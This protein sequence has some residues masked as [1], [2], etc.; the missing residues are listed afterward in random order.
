VI[1]DAAGDGTHII[2]GM[3]LVGLIFLGAIALGELIKVASHR[4]KAR[5]PSAY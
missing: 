1:F 3:L 5:R 4:R 2:L